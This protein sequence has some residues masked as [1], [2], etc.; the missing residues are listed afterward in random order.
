MS[1]AAITRWKIVCAYDGSSFTGWQSQPSRDAVQDFIEARLAMLLRAPTRIHGSGR[2]DAGVHAAGQVF[3]FDASW[4]HGGD[5]LRTALR[6]GLPTTIQIKS[7]S[8]A[9]AA[10]H[11]RF[12]AKGK[13]YSYHI[14]EGVADPFT[15]P[16]VYS[17]DHPRRLEKAAMQAAAELLVGRHDF[18]AFA[19]GNRA[20][21][22]DPVRDLSRISITSRGRSIKLVF[23]ANGFL[24]KMVRSLAGALMSVGA[25]RL[26]PADLVQIRES[27][28]RTEAVETA[29]AQGLFLERVFY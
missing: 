22:E 17:R 15:H 7:V 14:F 21:L 9:A 20:V 5:K 4:G 27:G 19:A 13:R 6:V 23:E 3:H 1:G 8:P 25:G 24:Y 16:F 26:S 28:V 2:T 12:S 29:P 18:R 11:A 10:F